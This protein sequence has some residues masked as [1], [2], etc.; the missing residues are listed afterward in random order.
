MQTLI[1]QGAMRDV[2]KGCGVNTGSDYA[3]ACPLLGLQA[4]PIRLFNTKVAARRR[5]TVFQL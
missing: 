5:Q 3:I 2:A 4:A 1:W